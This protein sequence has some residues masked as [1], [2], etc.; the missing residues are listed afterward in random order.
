MSNFS[1]FVKKDWLLYIFVHPAMHVF[2]DTGCTVFWRKGGK[3]GKNRKN[4][5]SKVPIHVL[6]FPLFFF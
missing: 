2:L 3:Q 1:F 5:K 4:N 6:G